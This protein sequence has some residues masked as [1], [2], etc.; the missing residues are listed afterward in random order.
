MEGRTPQGNA[1]ESPA[2]PHQRRVRYRGTHP[3]KF[4]EKYKEQNPEK[5]PETVAKVIASGKTPAGMHR[6]IMVE[7]ILRVLEVKPGQTVVDCTLGYGGH[8]AEILN[9]LRPGGRLVGL[10]ADPVEIARTEE[11][12][13]GAGWTAEALILRQTNFAALPRVLAELQIDAVDAI[14]GDLGISSMQLDDPMRGFTFKNDGPLDLRLNPKKGRSAADWLST[15]RYEKLVEVLREN[16]DEK[17]A[18]LFAEAIIQRQGEIRT[19]RQLA[20]IIKTAINPL[21]RAI[22]EREGDAPIRR[23]FQ[24]LRIAVNDEFAVLENLLRVIPQCLRPNGR[25][26]ILTFH[27]GED[28][29]VKRSFQEGERAGVYSSVADEPLRASA[30]EI[31]A[32]PRASS[33]KLRWAV[34][35]EQV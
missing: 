13:R 15:I 19:T 18:E 33:A 22:R 34:R 27:S 1:A 31:H 26:A 35:S 16:S 7:E 11:R 20:A 4:S 29:R 12:L 30:S 10:D 23:T 2:T 14:L 24:A 6:P 32:N 8:A 25:V 28:R 21:P 17:H 5:Y 3:R 9:R